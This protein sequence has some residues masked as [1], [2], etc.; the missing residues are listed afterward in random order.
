M[1]VAIEWI[2]LIR[3]SLLDVDAYLANDDKNKAWAK[4]HETIAMI[5]N[6]IKLEK[7]GK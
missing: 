5:T 7:E 6:E 3:E 1:I 2:E 4:L